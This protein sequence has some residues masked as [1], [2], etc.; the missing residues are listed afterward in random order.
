MKE[1]ASAPDGSAAPVRSPA[2]RRAAAILDC[3]AA[4]LFALA[5]AVALFGGVR[6]FVNNTRLSATSPTRLFLI[7]AVVVALRHVLSPRPSILSAARGALD[8]VRASASSATVAVVAPIWIATR[9]GVIVVA[10]I[11]VATIGLPPEVAQLRASDNAF[12]NLPFRWDTG[13]YLG[14]AVDGYR[15]DPRDRGQQ[16]IAFFPAYPLL[17]RGGGA[18][19]GARTDLPRTP[20]VQERLATR[21]LAA[22]WA[23]ALGASFAALCALYRWA[24]A[25]AG[26]RT[27]A[28]AVALC[29]AY[30]F[31]VYFSGAY[32][33]PLFLLG[34]IG[35]FNAMRAQQT[36]A[37]AAWGL[38]IGLLRPNGFLVAVPLMWMAV[39]QGRRDWRL[40]AAAVM[41]CVGMLIFSA[42]LWTLTGRPL[43]WMEAHAAWGRTPPT[44]DAAVTQP[45]SQVV[46]SGM[47]GYAMSAPYQLMNGAALLFA[48]ALVPAVWR[49][50]GAAPVLLVAVTLGPP[51][52]AGGLMSIGRLTAT[53]FPLFVALAAVLPRRYFQALLI[54]F[55]VGEGLAAVLFF[56]WRALV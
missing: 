53:I 42:Y 51:L 15:W 4:I 25:V 21:T 33:E 27:A 44:W 47:I 41:P 52:I 22:G 29:S 30:P 54:A 36:F 9:L 5:L 20:N 38:F 3:V 6:L 26:P 13:W 34:T 8:A 56:T 43:A 55:A 11:A 23:L 31:A 39:A 46:D 49:R 50:L 35:A 18:L 12:W 48:C 16:N 17:M 2:L 19:L 7:L 40:Q 24:S 37:L 32:T 10:F 45:L 14:I 1:W 28:R